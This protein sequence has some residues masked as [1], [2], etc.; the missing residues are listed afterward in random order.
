LVRKDRSGEI[1]V[2]PHIEQTL[3]PTPANPFAR[4]VPVKALDHFYDAGIAVDAR[5]GSL[6]IGSESDLGPD[7]PEGG[8]DPAKLL[9]T[10]D[11]LTEVLTRLRS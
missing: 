5:K 10:L 7:L 11:Q 6:L 9:A 4:V 8:E 1:L 2:W 3:T